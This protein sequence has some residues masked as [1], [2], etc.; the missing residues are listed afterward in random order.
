MGLGA[1]VAILEGDTVL[2][3]LR[4][5]F[6]VWCLPG[7]EIETGESVA[8]AARREAREETG[9]EVELTRLVGIYTQLGWGADHDLLF[10]A[11]I[12]G[13]TLKPDPNEVVEARFF[14]LDALPEHLLAG[15]S[16]MLADVAGGISGVVKTQRLT[17]APALPRER[18]AL[19]A[20]RDQ[21]GLSRREYYQQNFGDLKADAITIEVE[22]TAQSRS[23]SSQ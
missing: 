22:S 18:R 9:L 7:G 15:V 12:V 14:R 17:V 8:D 5:D 23:N 16:D 3:T 1:V 11:R 13:G 20:A 10:A 2:L 19:Y 6:E 4:E 21:S